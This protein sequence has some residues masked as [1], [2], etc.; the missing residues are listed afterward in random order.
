MLKL[1]DK[2]IWVARASILP[3]NTFATMTIVRLLDGG[4]VMISPIPL[5]PALKAEI[6]SL[7][8]VAMVVSPSRFH[9]MFAFDFLKHYPQAHYSYS[10]AVLKKTLEKVATLPNKLC[11]LPLGNFAELM[12]ILI[13]GMPKI[14]EFVFYHPGLKTLIA[15][16]FLFMVKETKNWWLKLFWKILG[17]TPL[18]PSQSR[19]F[20]SHIK[21]RQ[22]YDASLLMIKG[23]PIDRIIV[24]HEMTIE[25]DALKHAQ[26]IISPRH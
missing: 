26:K 23:L 2:N 9:H 22:A 8:Q 12:P 4:L 16:D 6:D 18:L 11:P 17:I 19:Y 13:D 10:A 5:S 7:G 24:A 21:D 14:Q 25:G 3:F 15:T 20:R 1:I